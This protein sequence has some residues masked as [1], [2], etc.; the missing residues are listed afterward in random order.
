MMMRGGEVRLWTRVNAVLALLVTVCALGVVALYASRALGGPLDPPGPVASTQ[1]LVEPRI[2][3]SQPA[4]AAGFPIVISQPGSY[5]LASN[6]TGVTGKAGISITASHVELDLNGF[7]VAGVP[8]ATNG[9][10]V[11]DFEDGL[12]IHSGVI[13]NWPG[14]GI[15]AGA[16]SGGTF[17]DLQIFSNGATGISVG[18][19][20]VI[21]RVEA[22]SHTG[23]GIQMTNVGSG[24]RIE[25]CVATFNGYG[26][27][28]N[29]NSV[30]VTGCVLTNNTV[31]GVDLGGNA[32]R[33]ELNMF[34]GNGVGVR[35]GGAF[36]AIVRNLVIQTAATAYQNFSND[37]HIGSSATIGAGTVSSTDTWSNIR[38]DP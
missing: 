15:E 11:P 10:A 4:S 28:V 35:A 37:N 22:R 5:Y 7:H 13:R 21:R 34:R 24:G 30:V 27:H 8:G 33:I 36:N 20:N 1:P 38:F 23:Q 19:G 29:G 26:V 9:I 32:N 6:I 3:I 16:A 14:S 31:A 12:R 2:P 17:E 18:A 25:D